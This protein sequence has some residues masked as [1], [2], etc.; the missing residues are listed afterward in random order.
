MSDVYNSSIAQKSKHKINETRTTIN[1]RSMADGSNKKK[2]MTPPWKNP[3]TFSL[4]MTNW[5][6]ICRYLN[7]SC[8]AYNSECCS[9]HSKEKLLKAFLFWGKKFQEFQTGS[10][11]TSPYKNNIMLS[12]GEICVA[13]FI[14]PLWMGRVRVII[15]CKKSINKLFMKKKLPVLI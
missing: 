15:S 2:I 7:R 14:P 6:Q 9:F 4:L 13:N 10:P 3:H 5:D 1:I 12:R 11:K 8:I